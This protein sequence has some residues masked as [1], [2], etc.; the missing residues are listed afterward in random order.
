MSVEFLFFHS[1]IYNI[2][3]LFNSIDLFLQLNLKLV[4]I[5]VPV[6]WL[7]LQQ[8]AFDCSSQLSTVWDISLS[9]LSEF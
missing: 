6:Q 4:S 3:K 7:N 5:V 8:S 1:G 9:D 2:Y